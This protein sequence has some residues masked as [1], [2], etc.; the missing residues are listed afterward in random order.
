M[1]LWSPEQLERVRAVI[2]KWHAAIALH[3]FGVKSLP[4]DLVKDLRGAG[5]DVS[6]A[7]Q[8]VR[9][10]FAYGQ[11]LAVLRNPA[12]AEKSP[13]EIA[14]LVEER[15]LALA[16]TS[17][18]K[19]AIEM[20]EKHA[21]QYVVGL[22]A[23]VTSSVMGLVTGAEANLPP[24]TMREVIQDATARNLARRGTV[25]RLK[26]DLG[27]AAEDWSRD[28][29]RVAVT[30]TNNAVQEGTAAVLERQHGEDVRVSKVPRPGACRDCLSLYLDVDGNPKVFKLSELRANGSNVGRRRTK[31]LPVVESTHPF[32]RC[33]LVRLPDGFGWIGG[34]LR[35]MPNADD[36]KKSEVRE[37][38]NPIALVLRLQKSEAPYVGPKQPRRRPC[39]S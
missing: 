11:L 32:C 22:G 4:P 36:V 18:E 6:D 35:M 39:V 37:W 29:Q 2:A 20:A 27:H 7:P 23:R 5:I 21:A 9:D 38:R 12:L 10:A 15:H 24:S 33:S 14:K 34:E 1:P 16:L 25:D 28:W 31:W 19:A 3:V 26:S 30:E 17:T 13:A 8:L